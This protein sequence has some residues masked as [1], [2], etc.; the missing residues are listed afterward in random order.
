M[1]FEEFPLAREIGL[2][3][4]PT[5][6]FHLHTNWTD[7]RAST[8]E[9]HKAACKQGLKKI[10][11]SEHARKTSGDWFLQFATEVRSLPSGDC[12]ALVGAEVKVEDFD[13]TLDSTPSIL[14]HCDLVMAVVHRF[15]GER[16]IIKGHGETNPEDAADIEYRLAMAGVRNPRTDILGH[17]FG[18]TVRRFGVEPSEEMFRDLMVQ[19]A[20]HNVAF[21][22]NPQYYSD[23][24]KLLSWC[25]EEN[26]RVSFGSNAHTPEEVGAVQR[27]LKGEEKSCKLSEL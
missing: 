18:M 25:K 20:E 3:S 4:L 12:K 8:Q 17:P 11:F 26:I 21:E 10:L 14:E 16:G 2:N 27:V 1:K 13:G 19:C 22:I 15:P 5:F 9:M 23:P 7:G 6:D 24:W